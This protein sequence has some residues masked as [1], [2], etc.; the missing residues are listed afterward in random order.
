MSQED[1][2]RC[3]GCND[4]TVRFLG[5]FPGYDGEGWK[6]YNVHGGC[7]GD[8]VPIGWC[9]FC[10]LKL[11]G[12]SR[13]EREAVE[14]IRDLGWTLGWLLRSTY[15]ARPIPRVIVDENVPGNHFYMVKVKI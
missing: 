14:A 5:T 13:D 15:K 12:L 11:E 10:G 1:A 3:P 9:P 6:L 8:D 7:D 2:P 4:Y